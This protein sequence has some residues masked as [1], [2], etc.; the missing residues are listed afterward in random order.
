MSSSVEYRTQQKC[1]AFQGSR[2]ALCVRGGHDQRHS[3]NTLLRVTSQ[4]QT[5]CSGRRVAQLQKAQSDTPGARQASLFGGGLRERP[6]TL[7]ALAG[8]Q[9]QPHPG[10][11]NRRVPVEPSPT[12]VENSRA[13]VS[14]RPF[15]LPFPRRRKASPELPSRNIDFRVGVLGSFAAC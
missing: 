6:A 10:S 12:A 8:A 1:S 14:R 11:G 5:S 7:S 2:L 13:S 3:R 4:F 9:R 15:A